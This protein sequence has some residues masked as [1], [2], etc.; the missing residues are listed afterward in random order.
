MALDLSVFRIIMRMRVIENIIIIVGLLRFITHFTIC[1]FSV[2]GNNAKLNVSNNAIKGPI[3]ERLGK[4]MQI[5]SINLSF[6]YF[7]GEIPIGLIENENLELLYVHVNNLSGIISESYCNRENPLKILFYGNAICPP[8]PECIKYI[9]K[10][11][12]KN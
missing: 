10:Q 9:G 3:V 7:D 12:C 11:N 4:L 6:N 1:R 2:L 5:K 8:Y